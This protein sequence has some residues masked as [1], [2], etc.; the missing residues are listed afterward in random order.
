MADYQNA[1][2]A[3]R[4]YNDFNTTN[5]NAW[6]FQGMCLGH[7]NNFDEAIVAFNQ[8]IA[9]DNN[10]IHSLTM[11]GKAYGIKGEYQKSIGYFERV[12]TIDPSNQEA[13]DNL[14]MTNEIIKSQSL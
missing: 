5:P 12:L 14:N 3:L 6:Y 13:R 2:T 9:F 10:H 7:L 1:L 11:L 4:T 8:S